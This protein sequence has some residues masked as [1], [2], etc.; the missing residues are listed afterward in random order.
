M[1]MLLTFI[2][3]GI[4]DHLNP[5]IVERTSFRTTKWDSPTLT[6]NKRIKKHFRQAQLN[7]EDRHA[8]NSRGRN[9]SNY[10]APT[11]DTFPRRFYG[12]DD[13][14]YDEIFLLEIL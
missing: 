10:S 11:I 12:F 4:S 7:L 3:L 5:Q 2:C 1:L 6:R 14:V 13:Y 9:E 8:A